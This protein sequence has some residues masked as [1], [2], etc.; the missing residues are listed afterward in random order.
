M[1]KE[2]AIKVSVNGTQQA[3]KNIG[4]LETAIQQMREELKGTAIGSTEFKK[5]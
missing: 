4:D 2:V 1:A 3:V 5:L